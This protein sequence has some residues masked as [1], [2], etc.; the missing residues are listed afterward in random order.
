MSIRDTK[1][2]RLDSIGG[3]SGVTSKP[4]PEYIR[5]PPQGVPCPLTGLSRAKM[6]QLVLPNERNG[7]SPPVRS[8]KVAPAKGR[9]GR[10]RLV[11]YSSLV[12]YL[13]SLE[14]GAR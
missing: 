4:L 12:S 5:L 3:D 6:S 14:G 10:V 1:K 2:G 9:K 8:V 13:N 11:N 7:F